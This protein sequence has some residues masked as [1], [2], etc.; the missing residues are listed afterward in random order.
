MYTNPVQLLFDGLVAQNILQVVFLISL[1]INCGSVKLDSSLD[2]IHIN[3]VYTC[4]NCDVEI[5]AL[6]STIFSCIILKCH[7]IYTDVFF[8]QT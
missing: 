5:K 7:H 6:F 1:V 8:H 4:N 2:L 3:T